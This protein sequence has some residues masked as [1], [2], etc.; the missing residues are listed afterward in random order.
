MPG[1]PVVTG[2]PRHTDDDVLCPVE[3]IWSQTQGR[4]AVYE[5]SGGVC[6]VTGFDVAA[7]WSHRLA[8]SQGGTWAPW[9]GL[10]VDALFHAWAHA[11]PALAVAGGWIVLPGVDPR[12]VPVWLA[13]PYPGW[14]LIGDPADGGP[15]VLTPW[16]PADGVH[17]P[18][19]VLP[20]WAR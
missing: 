7:H 19:P 9:N 18:T 15:H 11:N 4:K 14:W 8:R 5:R 16:A 13:R 3:G 1:V 20:G 12:T 2:F 6:E 17:H 10:H